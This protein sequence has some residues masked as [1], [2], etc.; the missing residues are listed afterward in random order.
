MGMMK[1]RCNRH[2]EWGKDLIDQ[3]KKS[4]DVSVNDQGN[5]GWGVFFLYRVVR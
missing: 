4:T 3:K 1:P 2:S 5:V